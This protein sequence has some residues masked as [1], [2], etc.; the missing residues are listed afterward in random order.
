MLFARMMDLGGAS[1]QEHQGRKGIRDLLE[2]TARTTTDT[3]VHSHELYAISRLAAV[4]QVVVKDD[5]RTARELACWRSLGHLLYAD[6]LVI[7]EDAVAE[8]CLK[9][10]SLV[11]LLRCHGGCGW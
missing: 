9:V 7:P 11:V 6:S 10:V 8:L 3:A 5:V 1:S 2:C 4:D